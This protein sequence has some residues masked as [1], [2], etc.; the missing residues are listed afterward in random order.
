MVNY[1]SLLDEVIDFLM[2]EIV[3]PRI[4][5]TRSDFQAIILVIEIL[6]VTFRR[7]GYKIKQIFDQKSTYSKKI[8]VFSNI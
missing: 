6:V 2:A 1:P 8:I 7:E 3:K 5:T 4:T